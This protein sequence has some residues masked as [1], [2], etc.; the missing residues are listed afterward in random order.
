MDLHIH[1]VASHHA[2]GT[3]YDICK[4]ASK[5]KMQII[6]LTDHSPMNQFDEKIW[7]FG[8]GYRAP[9][10]IDGVRLLWGA[11]ANLI[12]LNGDL[13]LPEFLQ[14]KLEFLAFGYH[15][16]QPGEI[17]VDEKFAKAT[18][19]EITNAMLKALDNP[20]VKLVTHPCGYKSTFD[21]KKV[22]NKALNNNILVE[23]NVSKFK[24]DLEDN[25]LNPYKWTIAAA[26]KN[27]KK[28][29]IGTDSH[30]LH[31]IGDD[32]IILEHWDELGLEKE[33]IIN[34]YPNELMKYLNL[35]Y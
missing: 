6:A 11:E 26:K 16:T 2:Y 9:K 33:I 14:K 29:S 34:N 17:G 35:E 8:T 32:S 24:K 13:G 23:I 10:S 7:H 27:G 4:E 18:E 20:Y 5:K 22:I 28:I 30:F 25:N 19:D 21:Y 15:K 3:I 31:E 12:N 1:S